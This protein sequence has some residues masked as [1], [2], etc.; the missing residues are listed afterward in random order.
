MVN[1]KVIKKQLQVLRRTLIE[2]IILLI[3]FICLGILDILTGIGIL[4]MFFLAVIIVISLMVSSGII[5]IYKQW[6]RIKAKL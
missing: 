3:T 1:E 2:G 6:K 4:H 5:P